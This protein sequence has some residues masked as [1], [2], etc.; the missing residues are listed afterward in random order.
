MK[1]KRFSIGILMEFGAALFLSLNKYFEL[2]CPSL[3]LW[4]YPCFQFDVLMTL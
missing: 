2:L 4:K 3:V 1:K